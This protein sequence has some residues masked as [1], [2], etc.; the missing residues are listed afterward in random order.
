MA[1][2]AIALV[3][4]CVDAVERSRS[5]HDLTSEL[6][7]TQEEA[8][9]RIA[10]VEGELLAD[11]FDLVLAAGRDPDYEALLMAQLEVTGE[12]TPTELAAA[13]RDRGFAAIQTSFDLG[14]PTPEYQG[15]PFWPP[16]VVAAAQ[17]RYCE[18]WQGGF[19]WL[20]EP[21]AS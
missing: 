14:A 17:G 1:V 8:V 7:P 4:A 9:Q 16:S 12:R 5:L 21:C 13:V 10:G 15:L 6:G 19:V 18:I 2:L 3:P 11:R 20:Y